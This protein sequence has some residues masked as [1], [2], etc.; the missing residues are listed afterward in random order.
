MFVT[1]YLV[2]SH[3][4]ILVAGTSPT[5][6]VTGHAPI[7]QPLARDIGLLHASH[8]A[9]PMITSCMGWS[10]RR[11]SQAVSTLSS[12]VSTTKKDHKTT[13]WSLNKVI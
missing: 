4:V 11:S 8:I 12:A 2:E 7:A 10:L 3:I 5:E 6:R 13:R 1:Q 9:S